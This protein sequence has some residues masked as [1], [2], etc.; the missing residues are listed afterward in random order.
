MTRQTQLVLIMWWFIHHLDNSVLAP[1]IASE[2]MGLL[3]CQLLFV[4]CPGGSFEGIFVKVRRCQWETSQ[5]ADIL[6]G[7]GQ[8]HNQNT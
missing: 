2:A 5:Q 7:P 4:F 1:A 8:R 3:F 6:F